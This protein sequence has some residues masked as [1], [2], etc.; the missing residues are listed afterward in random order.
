MNLAPSDHVRVLAPAFYAGRTGNVALVREP[1]MSIWPV[2]VA[3]DD[4]ATLRYG[5]F[6]P[7]ELERSSS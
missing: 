5:A 4:A 1:D 6:K 7:E 2:L 3:F